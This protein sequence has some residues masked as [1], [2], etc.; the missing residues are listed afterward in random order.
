MSAPNLG[1][2]GLGH[3][4]PIEGMPPD[5][6]PGTAHGALG[7]ALGRQG[8]HHRPLGDRRHRPGPAVP[9]VSRRVPAG[10]RSG[11]S[12]PA[13]GPEGARATRP[14]SGTEI[15]E[16]LGEEHLR[17]GEPIVYTSGDSVFQIATHVDVVPLEQL[18]EWCRTAREI[19]HRATTRWAGSS[20]GRSRAVPGAFV[21][22]PERRDYSVAPPPRPTLLEQVMDAG[23]PVYGVGKIRD[24]FVERGLTEATYSD[25][26]DD[27]V[28]KTIEYL[29]RPGPSLVVTNLVDF[30]S[31][32]GHRNDPEGYARCVEALDRADARAARGAG[33]RRR[34][35]SSPATTGATRPP[36]P[37]TTPGSGPR[38]WWPGWATTARRW[39]LGD[40]AASPTSARRS[41]S[42][43][44]VPDRGP[45]GDELRARSWA[46]PA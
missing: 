34:C 19:L 22:R 1:R 18:Y 2:L 14:A 3:L 23:V 46:A 15:I 17:T 13:I 37:P 27:G 40:R 45:G 32:Y 6:A 42:V 33:G 44:H 25:S 30:D 9:A 36:R 24:I 16:E 12:R 10:G 28:D 31:K 39:T 38:A 20:P 5:A 29:G 4:T 11:R 43:L 21:R 41:P 8:H 35:C 26:N 7:R